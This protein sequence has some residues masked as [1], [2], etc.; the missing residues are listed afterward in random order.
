MKFIVVESPYAGDVE[1][2]TEFVKAV[3]RHLAL[4]GDAPYAS[5]LFFTQFL[6]DRLDREREIGMKAGLFIGI[7]C[8]EA[9]FCLLQDKHFE[10]S[11]G[12]KMALEHWK[13]KGVKCTLFWYRWFHDPEGKVVLPVRFETL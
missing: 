5:H 12:M 10:L 4:Q 7:G 11:T 8:D 2:N 13:A 1:G 6:D 3:C 9:H